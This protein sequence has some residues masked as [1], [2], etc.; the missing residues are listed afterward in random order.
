[1]NRT[2]HPVKVF[3]AP[4]PMHTLAATIGIWKL[5]G[6]LFLCW[7]NFYCWRLLWRPF[8]RM[9]PFDLEKYS[10][11]LDWIGSHGQ[12]LCG[13]SHI[14]CIPA[15]S[16]PQDQNRWRRLWADWTAERKLRLPQIAPTSL[17]LHKMQPKRQPSLSYSSSG[18]H[19]WIQSTKSLCRCRQF[20]S[21]SVGQQGFCQWR[22]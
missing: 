22:S 18:P 1:M 14:W 3:Q 12:L 2:R 6:N 16:H 7:F 5:N 4:P 9:T 13:F 15:D 8:F 11:W 19:P 20:C 21:T 17:E 10:F